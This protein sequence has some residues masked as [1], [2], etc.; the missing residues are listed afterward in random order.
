MK[1]A[2]YIGDL[3]YD[4]ECVVIPGLGGFLTQDKPASIQPNTH[5]FRPPYKQVM[6]NAY[7]KTNDGLLVNYIAREENISYKEAKAQV[8][9]F[10][11]LC[12]NALKNGKRINFQKVG[13]L[14]LNKNEK[15]V[16]E[17]DSTINY[18]ADAFGLTAFVS[19]AVRRATPEEKLRE[20]VLSG[21]EKEQS[22]TKQT[23]HTDRKPPVS[24]PAPHA[25]KHL[26]ATRKKSPYRSQLAFLVVL[27]IAMMVGWGFMNKDRVNAY[28]NNYS[29]VIPFFYN[30]PN[31]YVINNIDKV[32]IAKVSSSRF[33]SWWVHLF[34]KSAGKS[35]SR[36]V[37]KA[38]ISHQSKP[39]PVRAARPVT[40]KATVV[41]TA[42]NNLAIAEPHHSTV[43]KHMAAKAKPLP[44]KAVSQPVASRQKL[45]GHRYYIIAGAFK[46]TRNVMAMIRMLRSKGYQPLVAGETPYG[47]HRVAFGVFD[48]RNQARKMLASIRQKDNPAAWILVK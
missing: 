8:D 43:A 34:E 17:Q 14:Y 39:Q 7:L 41:K 44:A 11:Y 5:H 22:R 19:P 15:I 4:Y 42:K 28:Y 2:K 47:L 9:K 27:I 10:V 20:K 6:F 29:S 23:T 18:Q 1:I 26:V 48:Q 13:A 32:P 37:K 45:S 35:L 40:K 16:F 21:K 25:H 38:A 12:N 46:S 31:A 30:Q 36:P 33:G 3:L 24:S